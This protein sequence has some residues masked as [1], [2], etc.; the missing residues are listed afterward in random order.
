MDILEVLQEK[1]KEEQWTRA[2]IE[3][4]SVKDLEALEEMV[5]SILQAHL[6][7]KA[8]NM[9]LEFLKHSPK[10]II[11]LYILGFLSYE[12]D[13]KENADAI[14]Q[15]I[16]IFKENKKWNIVEALLIKVLEY[17]HNNIYALNL[18][19]SLYSNLKKEEEKINTLIKLVKIDTTN[20]EAAQ[21]LAE[22]YEK[23]EADAILDGKFEEEDQKKKQE[24]EST[25]YYKLALRRYAKVKHSRVEEI[26]KK[27]SPEI[28]YETNFF[29]NIASIV[30]EYN[31][32]LS[33]NLLSNI[34]EILEIENKIEESIFVAKKI[35][36]LDPKNQKMR[37]KL[38]SLYEIK[39][40]DNAQFSHCI[41]NSELRD[42]KV[43]ITS[44]IK[45][46]EKEILFEEDGYVYHRT[47]GIGTLNKLDNENFTL[48]FDDKEDHQMSY[49]MALKSLTPL[50]ADH[51][52]VLKKEGKI[53]DIT[54][55]SE[56]RRIL[57]SI[58]ESFSG[59]S[60]SIE[61]FKE[62]L[63]PDIIAAKSWNSWW[64]KAKTVFKEEPSIGTV[65]EG[66]PK[67]FIRTI[68]IRFEEELIDTFAQ[69]KNFDEK[70]KTFEEFRKDSHS[71]EEYSDDF[72]EM[73]NFFKDVIEAQ[74]YDFHE[75]LISFVL[76]KRL[77]K[78]DSW[79]I[80]E[81]PG[82]A[83]DF[84]QI[85]PIIDLLAQNYKAEYKKDIVDLVNEYSSD[86]IGDLTNILF[87]DRGQLAGYIMEKFDDL[88][89][90]EKRTSLIEQ[91]LNQ[92]FKNNPNIT[93]WFLQYLLLEK[94]YLDYA[95][96]L[97]DLYIE[98]LYRIDTVGKLITQKKLNWF[99]PALYT[100]EA[101]KILSLANDFLF[102]D[103][104]FQSFV[105][106]HE[107]KSYVVKI[108]HLMKTS[109]GMNAK[110]KSTI[111]KLILEKYPDIERIQSDEDL[112]THV[113]VDYFNESTIWTSQRGLEAQQEKLAEL[114]EEKDKNLID[115]ER[116][117]EKGD[118]RENAEYQA[119]REKD[120]HLNNQ[121]MELSDK[122]KK[123][124]VLDFSN[125][126][127][128][129]AIPGTT[130]TIKRDG[131]EETYTI[132]GYWDT[133]EKNHIIAYNSPLAK[134]ILGAKA[135]DTVNMELGGDKITV[136]ILNVEAAQ[137]K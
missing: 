62:E 113:K 121:I 116:A 127:G 75:K 87:H 23:I 53:G 98:T 59:K 137:V 122:V 105:K 100:S 81:I 5:N 91:A 86:Q 31:L 101:K 77:Q 65:K 76:L 130:V 80:D 27:L 119:A 39:Y 43:K 117:R 3:N 41:E 18:L 12:L 73:V 55:P 51:I 69:S 85:D 26:W 15:V 66:R 78:T 6:E 30:A 118:L 13:D 106:N 111:L 56:M 21:K 16:E 19:V 136:E 24:R 128:E 84:I 32:D 45:K 67:Y 79:A 104:S 110:K 125:I 68:K 14:I 72:K 103:T 40:G 49:T 29:L 89:D 20:G 129:E 97:E 35:L 108:Y 33:V 92:H 10:S 82:N 71:L 28:Y 133:D 132:L 57:L 22:Y 11:G 63:V 52:W 90:Q 124:K 4:Y 61:N 88:L 50:K 120:T 112:V 64:N 95:F 46:F 131:K 114:K 115:L 34:L 83:M 37:E 96:K 44:A 38:I 94:K 60:L 47:W 9:C 93:V 54:E 74:R 135:G 17:D 36:L 8:H 1:L 58:L 134:G 70:L 25:R 7:E 48:S 42:E 126:S 107:D 123:S 99:Q 109:T 2:T 102:K